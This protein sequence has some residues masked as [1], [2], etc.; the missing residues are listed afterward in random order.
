M[1]AEVVAVEKGLGHDVRFALQGQR[2]VGHAGYG[3]EDY[4]VVGGFVGGAAPDEGGVACD[5]AGGDG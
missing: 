3:F 1:F 5:Q 4:R 2:A